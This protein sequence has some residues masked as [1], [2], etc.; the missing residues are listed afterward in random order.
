[1]LLVEFTNAKLTVPVETA[2]T[3]AWLEREGSI[4][5]STSVSQL[6]YNL[7]FF[8]SFTINSVYC[9]YKLILC[10]IFEKW[11]K[12][13]WDDAMVFCITA[14]NKNSGHVYDTNLFCSAR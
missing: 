9:Y 3:A 14:E 4:P 13:L 7:V 1:M 11:Q 12:N 10:N 6:F 5:F 8:F 2:T